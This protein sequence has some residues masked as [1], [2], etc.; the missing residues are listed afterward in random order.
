[1]VV[2]LPALRIGVD[3]AHGVRLPYQPDVDNG[4]IALYVADVTGGHI[5]RKRSSDMERKL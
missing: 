2:G 4:H 5:V 3:R 1:V